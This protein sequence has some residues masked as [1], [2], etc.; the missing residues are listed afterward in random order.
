MGLAYP[1]FALERSILFNAFF[2]RSKGFAFD[3]IWV[4]KS[5]ITLPDISPYYLPKNCYQQSS[6][7][8]SLYLI[9]PML[10]DRVVGVGRSHRNL[11]NFAIR[12]QIGDF[13]YDGDESFGLLEYH[14][15]AIASITIQF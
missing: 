3:F 15:V 9:L 8:R 7:K 12:C 13:A 5:I 6:R 2:H 11:A 10:S 14:P 1:F 4:Q